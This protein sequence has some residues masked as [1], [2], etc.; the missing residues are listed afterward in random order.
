MPQ[1]LL[2]MR[3]MMVL[4]IGVLLI[5]TIQVILP[6]HLQLTAMEIKMVMVTSIVQELLGD[7]MQIMANY[8]I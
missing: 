4:A 2:T 7:F 5:Q 1:L 6:I 8:L 3:L